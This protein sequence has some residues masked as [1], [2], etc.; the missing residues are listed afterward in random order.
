MNMKKWSMKLKEILDNWEDSYYQGSEEL[1]AD[2]EDLSK[3]SKNDELLEDDKSVIEFLHLVEEYKKGNIKSDEDLME[4]L[5][6]VYE[7]LGLSDSFI[8]EAEGGN[9]DEIWD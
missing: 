3:K 4:K 1:L 9:V 2:L 8:D 6:T 5:Q 7:H